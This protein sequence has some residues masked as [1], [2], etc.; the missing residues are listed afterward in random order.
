LEVN[1]FDFD[2]DL[3]GQE[4]RIEFIKMLR[5]ERKFDTLEDLQAEIHRNCLQAQEYFR[6]E[7][8]QS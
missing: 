3:Y 8:S 6:T 4:V 1:I 7:R 5:P 2:G